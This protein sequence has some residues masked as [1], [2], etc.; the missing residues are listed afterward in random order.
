MT[1]GQMAK[2]IGKRVLLKVEQQLM[3]EVEI[4]DA[5]KSWNRI[6]YL[7]SAIEGQGY[8]AMWVSEARV[9]FQEE[10]VEE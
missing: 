9:E 1:A 8:G 2:D 7:V 3:L 4:M 6:D 10:V 5:R